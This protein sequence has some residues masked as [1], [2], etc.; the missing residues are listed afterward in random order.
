MA[1]SR[2]RGFTLIELLVVIAIIGI[3]VAMLLP[4]VQQARE[5]A[6]RTECKN[7][8]KQIGIALHNYHDAHRM[9]PSGW[10]GATP[11]AP[12]GGHDVE[13][14]NGF[15]WG[16]MILP[17]MDAGPLYNQFDFNRSIVDPLHAD[18][19]KKNLPY[20]RCPSDV[21]EGTWGIE[22]HDNPGVILAELAISNYVGN[23]G[24]GPGPLLGRDLDS[25]EGLVGP[26]TS[27]GIFYHNSR[28]AMR[29]IDDGTTTTLFVG[30]RGT[31]TIPGGETL[32]STWSGSIPHGVDHFAR[33]LGVT[34]HAPNSINT[35]V[36]HLDDYSS[37][38]EGGAQFVFG[39]GH[40][41]FIS[42]NIDFDTYQALATR[43]GDETI[44]EF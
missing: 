25:C 36:P 1:V 40:V 28:V 14:M 31:I 18:L 42:E 35:T 7:N 5:A 15:G 10:I 24:S 32:Y 44:G 3:L 11:G 21:G 43:N 30:E 13:G 23:F 26:C 33:I 9:F 12:Q 6:R 29:D 17:Y 20:N 38:H 41:Q 22:D 2:R 4:A 8:L 16:T 39:D 37:W 27:N 34:D 19:I